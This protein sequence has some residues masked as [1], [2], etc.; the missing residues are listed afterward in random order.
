MIERGVHGPI[1]AAAGAAKAR[2]ATARSA[3]R[4]IGLLTFT[5]TDRGF[6]RAVAAAAHAAAWKHAFRRIAVL[7]DSGD[8]PTELVQGKETVVRRRG[9]EWSFTL[10]DRHDLAIDQEAHTV[11]LSMPGEGSAYELAGIEET[12]S[13]VIVQLGP[14]IGSHTTGTGQPMKWPKGYPLPE[15]GRVQ[16]LKAR[17]LR[18]GLPQQEF[19]AWAQGAT[20]ESQLS[21]IRARRREAPTG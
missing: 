19:D 17:W 15:S 3:A 8:V 16:R 5:R 6:K 2:Q 18:A 7:I 20:H 9:A 10:P 14:E 12:D 1:A 21:R 13:E 4:F 11:S